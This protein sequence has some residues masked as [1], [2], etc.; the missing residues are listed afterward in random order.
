[1]KG[2]PGEIGDKKMSGLLGHSGAGGGG[3]ICLDR[4][5]VE[6]ELAKIGRGCLPQAN[7][8]EKLKL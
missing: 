1:M 8:S 3:Q 7:Q 2:K 5:K 4:I 6:R